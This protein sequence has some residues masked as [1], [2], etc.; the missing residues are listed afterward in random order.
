MDQNT[1]WQF[2]GLLLKLH[3]IQ[4]TVDA[5]SLRDFS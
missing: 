4:K 5:L 1:D 2:V 3:S